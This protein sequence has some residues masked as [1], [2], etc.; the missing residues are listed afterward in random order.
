MP[1]TT[2]QPPG[3][4]GPL[5]DQRAAVIFLLGALVGLGAGALTLLGGGNWPMAVTA[6]GTAAPAAVLFFHQ[7]IE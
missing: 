1:T 6:A 4:G 2:P 5:L 3:G 7:I